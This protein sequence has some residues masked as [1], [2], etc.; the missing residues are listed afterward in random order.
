MIYCHW[1]KKFLESFILN[2]DGCVKITE[3]RQT[4][5]LPYYETMAEKKDKRLLY[6]C[7]IYMYSRYRVVFLSFFSTIVL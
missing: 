6:T 1:G 5:R 7:C 2:R 4:R 3:A